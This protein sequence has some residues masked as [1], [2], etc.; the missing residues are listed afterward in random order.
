VSG[1]EDAVTADV[2][3]VVAGVLDDVAGALGAGVAGVAGAEAGAAA[4]R[5][6]NTGGPS[7]AAP[8]GVAMISARSAP[9]SASTT[10][11]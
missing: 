7:A 10:A 2:V 4:N 3:G 11:R 5:S 1:R 9:S 8:P 6:I